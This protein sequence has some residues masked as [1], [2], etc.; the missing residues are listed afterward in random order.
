MSAPLPP[1][2][3]DEIE[4]A[5]NRA[6]I[7]RLGPR[8]VA[9]APA[10]GE[11]A[12]PLR[13]FAG[14]ALLL[15]VALAVALYYLW[16][17]FDQGPDHLP[18]IT[19][20][21][22]IGGKV[23]FF[24]DPEVVRILKER[25]G[26][27]VKYERVGSLEQVDRCTADHDYCWPSSQIASEKIKQK[28]ATELLGSEIIF[29]SPI[30]FYTWAPI[31]DALIAEGIVEKEGETH[32]LVDVARLVEMVDEG[33]QWSEIGLPQLHGNI[34]IYSSNPTKSNTGNAFAALLANTY[35]G[36]QV[37]DEASV[38]STLPRLHAFFARL[39]LLPEFTTE[40]FNQF[41]TQGMGAW[42]II[43]AYESN[44][45]EYGLQN[46]SAEDQAVIR[47]KVRT[48]YP[49][50][51]LWSAHTLI[52]LSPGGE[53]LMAALA[54]P[55]IQWIGWER[56]GFRSAVP[57]VHN[58]PAAVSVPGVPAEHRLGH[59]DAGAGGDG[60]DRCRPRR[61]ADRGRPTRGAHRLTHDAGNRRVSAFGSARAL[62]GHRR[63]RHGRRRRLPGDE[64]PMGINHAIEPISVATTPDAKPGLDD[65]TA[66]APR[67]PPC[68]API[69]AAGRRHGARRR[70]GGQQP[71]VGRAQ[72]GG[73]R[74]PSSGQRP[75]AGAKGGRAMSTGRIIFLN[76]RQVEFGAVGQA[77]L[78][79]DYA[80]T[81]RFLRCGIV[82]R[83]L[84]LDHHVPV[85][86][87]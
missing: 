59:A 79:R 23:A 72:P 75:C 83:T 52:A 34:S 74:L 18:A 25:Y 7:A 66:P 37:V 50:P 24:E 51:I 86:A 35:N 4:P 55:E 19:V 60:P 68:L 12:G 57:S 1:E 69:P 20:D 78:P 39:G 28:L 11:T 77:R 70:G 47:E 27:T 56:H 42:P 80:L 13:Q 48:L 8:P 61:H 10:D 16:P 84:T 43:V 30:V 15:A 22:I 62:S 31:A 63:E 76:A 54:D 49:R 32:Y 45:I 17:A 36:G 65:A 26:L 40:L 33:R 82:D 73:G 71:D 58:D 38:E 21:G 5:R 67:R 2:R 85:L 46:T 9:A 81:C 6:G 29:N 14:L 41:M 3:S 53:R 87:R 64:A 44:L